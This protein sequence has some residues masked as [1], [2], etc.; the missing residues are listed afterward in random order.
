MERN[1]D[2]RVETLVPV[3]HPK[4]QAWLDRVL[5]FHFAD[6]VVAFDLQ[7]DNTWVRTGPE[8]G[9]EP[10]SQERMY[11]WVSTTQRR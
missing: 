4:H 8:E 7:P 3:I 10:N 9:F 1:L 2:R 11:E 5:E 6:D